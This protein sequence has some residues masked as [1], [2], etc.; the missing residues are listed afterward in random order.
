MQFSAIFRDAGL[1]ADERRIG[2]RI[3]GSGHISLEVP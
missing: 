2:T 3:H 1:K